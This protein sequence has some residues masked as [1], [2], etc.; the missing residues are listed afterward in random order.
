MAHQRTEI[1]AKIADVLSKRV[2]FTDKVF[3]N[4]KT[5][6]FPEELPLVVVHT[7]D[8][9]VEVFAA[10]PRILL[11]RLTVVVEAAARGDELDD[12][13]DAHAAEIERALAP[14][15]RLGG[16]TRD[17]VLVKAETEIDPGGDMLM[18]SVRLTYQAIYLTDET[19]PQVMEAFKEAH[20]HIV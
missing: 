7:P 11:R 5:D 2:R 6:L 3:P 20:V 8:E 13:L 12:R 4:R 15:E 19:V 16:L 10:A 9:D 17:L 18:G 14:E 1:R